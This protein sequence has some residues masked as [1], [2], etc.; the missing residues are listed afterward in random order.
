M[1]DGGWKL[2]G[3]TGGGYQLNRDGSRNE[4]RQIGWFVGWIT[5]GSRTIIFA[6]YI[7][8]KEKIEGSAGKRAKEEA[9]E[10]I[11]QW[12]KARLNDEITGMATSAKPEGH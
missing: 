10:K 4:D 11:V 1:L 8:D 2:Y 3:K 6:C 5:K 9:K 12:I 7:E